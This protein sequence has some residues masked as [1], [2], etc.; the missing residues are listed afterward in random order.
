MIQARRPVEVPSSA[1]YSYLCGP[2]QVTLSVSVSSSVKSN[3]S[4]TSS[5]GC[6][7]DEV[8]RAGKALIRTE[9]SVGTHVCEGLRLLSPLP[10]LVCGGSLSDEVFI[11][12]IFI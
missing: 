1:S 8:G 3:E 10:Q 12:K 2:G 4:T 6:R 7:E 5:H 11:Y 9:P